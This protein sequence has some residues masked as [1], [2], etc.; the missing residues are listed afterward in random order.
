MSPLTIEFQRGIAIYTIVILIA[1]KSYA[2]I[3]SVIV[4]SENN[5]NENKIF[6]H[7]SDKAKSI[8]I[9][10]AIRRLNNESEHVCTQKREAK[11]IQKWEEHVT[12]Y[13]DSHDAAS[14]VAFQ[15]EQ[16]SAALLAIPQNTLYSLNHG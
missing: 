14:N 5:Y 3:L 8:P 15:N 4:G 13:K 2:D 11:I 12:A 1:A 10:N 6:Q 9:Y 7:Y 16:K